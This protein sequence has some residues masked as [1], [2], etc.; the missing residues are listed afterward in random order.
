MST[1]STKSSSS[2]LNTALDRANEFHTYI[3]KECEFFKSYYSTYIYRVI[4]QWDSIQSIEAAELYKYDDQALKII[5]SHFGATKPKWCN[6][7]E[8]TAAKLLDDL[9]THDQKSGNLILPFDLIV[10]MLD[11]FFT[12]FDHSFKQLIKQLK[13]HEIMYH[14]DADCMMNLG[15]WSSI[16]SN[17]EYNQLSP[18]GSRL[19]YFAEAMN[20]QPIGVID[21]FE[22]HLEPR[23][24]Q[25][26][27][28]P[29][30]AWIEDINAAQLML[31]SVYKQFRSHFDHL[32]FHG[33]DNTV[34]KAQ[35]T[36]LIKNTKKNRI[37]LKSTT[38]KHKIAP[39]PSIKDSSPETAEE[40]NL[41][42]L[43]RLEIGINLFSEVELE[44]LEDRIN[45][46]ISKSPDTIP[47]KILNEVF[48]EIY[49][50]EN[51]KFPPIIQMIEGSPTIWASDSNVPAIVVI[52]KR[53]AQSNN[54]KARLSAYI[55]VMHELG[56]E[57]AD[58]FKHDAL[59][60]EL[61]YAIDQKIK[62]NRKR[63]TKRIKKIWKSWISELFA[64]AVGIALLG[65]TAMDG[66][67][68]VLKNNGHPGELIRA[69]A[70]GTGYD[71][72]PNPY[73]R[74]LMAIKIHNL[75][76]NKKV[77]RSLSKIKNGTSILRDQY[78]MKDIP[79]RRLSRDIENM[80]KLI[81]NTP[82]IC[83]NGLTLIDLG[84]VITDS[85]EF[86][87]FKGRF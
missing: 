23:A 87:E 19:I 20:H 44:D 74:S 66:L 38:K 82:F 8:A 76:F 71:P 80:S 1:N 73:M 52:N 47:Q 79:L 58:D 67:I 14:A 85:A 54:K 30:P 13:S 65:E 28:Q 60:E 33:D 32:T 81:V 56:H 9:R 55:P 18:F 72:H 45:K 36:S 15:L 86:K 12:K 4:S 3:K 50:K 11:N 35:L 63:R 43:K 41:D 77:T 26:G 5:K 27:S 53:L 68:K 62:T 48:K 29:L 31:I 46:I 21:A 78:L 39:V 25:G 37:D 2:G 22:Q 10:E 57:I 42:L 49:I 17:D 6:L 84:K 16:Y 83:L 40:G 61:K 24:S 70:Q 64:D 75:I 7:S 51:Y 69:N 59:I 34:T